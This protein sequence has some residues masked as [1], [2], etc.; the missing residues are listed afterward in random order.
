MLTPIL[1]MKSVL[2][3]MMSRRWGRIVNITSASVKSPV[4]ELGLS[5]CLVPAFGGADRVES[6]GSFVQ[7]LQMNSYGVRPLRVLSRR[8][9]LYAVTKSA[10]WAR[11][12]PCVS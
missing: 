1:L 9:K 12:S 6:V 7:S 10:R 2:P 8:A 3:G 5:S 11:S 4:A